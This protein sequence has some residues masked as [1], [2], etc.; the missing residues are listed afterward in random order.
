MPKEPRSPRFVNEEFEASPQLKDRAGEPIEVALGAV[1][2]LTDHDVAAVVA[3][4]LR[5]H[6]TQPSAVEG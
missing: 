1:R 3:A 6:R 2:E 4:Q 5:R